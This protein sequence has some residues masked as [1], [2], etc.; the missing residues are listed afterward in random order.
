MEF[1]VVYSVVDIVHAGL[2]IWGGDCYGALQDPELRELAALLPSL[3]LDKWSDNT[4][5]ANAGAFNKWR[6]WANQ[7]DEVCLL[8]ASPGY[9]CLY[10]V[11]LGNKEYQCLQLMLQ[12]QGLTGLISWPD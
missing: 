3:L 6:K 11:A 10:L 8:P 12:L 2:G 4:S 1:N 7:F 9:F 5:Q